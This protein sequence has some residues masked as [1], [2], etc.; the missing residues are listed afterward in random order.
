MLLDLA[1]MFFD[2]IPAGLVNLGGWSYQTNGKRLRCLLP[3]VIGVLVTTDGARSVSTPVSPVSSP[4][5]LRKLKKRVSARRRL[6]SVR[7]SEGNTGSIEE[8]EMLLVAYFVV[9]NSTLNKLTS[10]IVNPF[11]ASSSILR[12]RRFGSYICFLDQL[13]EYIDEPIENFINIKPVCI[14]V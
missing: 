7:S 11:W 5:S 2:K 14:V 9:I 1:M 3:N 13:K 4:P 10:I 6:E 12:G 8:L